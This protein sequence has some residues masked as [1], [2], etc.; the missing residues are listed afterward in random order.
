MGAHLRVLAP[1][2]VPSLREAVLVRHARDSLYLA[3]PSGWR[4]GLPLS[5]MQSLQLKHESTGRG[6]AR[7]F[8][9]GFGIGSAVGVAFALSPWAADRRS[10]NT[11]AY[12]RNGIVFAGGL[13]GF[14]GAVL[15]AGSGSTW[16]TDVAPHE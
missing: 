14:L 13:G 5:S 7:G 8:A 10:D 6:A 15:G 1:P 2:A 12:I 11:A 16:W 4:V 3:D 9:W